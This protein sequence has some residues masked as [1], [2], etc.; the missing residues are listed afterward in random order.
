MYITNDTVAYKTD[1]GIRVIQNRDLDKLEQP[2]RT[3]LILIDDKTKVSRYKT[4]LDSY[5]GAAQFGGVKKML[6]EL[7]KHGLVDFHNVQ[8]KPANIRP[9]GK[10]GARTDRRH[11]TQDANRPIE[12]KYSNKV[13]LQDD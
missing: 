7:Y 2:L 4:L 8:K 3:L 1:L 6:K 5:S 12:P 13:S 11:R 10:S 9:A